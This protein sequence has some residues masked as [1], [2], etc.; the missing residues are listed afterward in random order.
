MVFLCQPLFHRHFG[1]WWDALHLLQSANVAICIAGGSSPDPSYEQ[2]ASIL[3]RLGWK[4]L[5]QP[6]GGGKQILNPYRMEIQTPDGFTASS[7]G[8]GAG[9]NKANKS[10]IPERP[11]KCHHLILAKG[12]K[13]LCLSQGLL[14]TKI[15]LL[16]QDLH[17]A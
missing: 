4:F 16:A 7:T 2:D 1:E 6:G 14:K 15:E 8:V 3:D 11:A 9:G 17:I 13:P 10:K 12:G 5:Q